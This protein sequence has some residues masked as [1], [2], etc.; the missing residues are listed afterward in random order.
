MKKSNLLC[1]FLEKKIEMENVANFAERSMPR[2][3][4]FRVETTEDLID[5]C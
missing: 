5:P 2:E 1:I 3:R 4:M